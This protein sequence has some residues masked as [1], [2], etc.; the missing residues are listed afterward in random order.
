MPRLLPRRGR[1]LVLV[2]LPWVPAGVAVELCVAEA[3]E[4]VPVAH[5]EDVEYNLLR[6]RAEYPGSV[7]GGSE[8]SQTLG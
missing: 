5:V 6:Q 1:G 4:V 8:L 7:T 3:A 2:A